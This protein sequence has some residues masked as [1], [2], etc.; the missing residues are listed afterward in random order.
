MCCCDNRTTLTTIGMKDPV[1]RMSVYSAKAAGLSAYS[2]TTY[3]FCSMDD[4]QKFDD[5]PDRYVRQS[6]EKDPV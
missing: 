2:G 6:L 5:T 1:C 4:K 3:Y